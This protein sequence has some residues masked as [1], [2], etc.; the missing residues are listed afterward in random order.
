MTPEA[1]FEAGQLAV[2]ESP[3]QINNGRIVRILLPARPGDKFGETPRLRSSAPQDRV[4]WFVVPID[5]KPLMVKLMNGRN[6]L[7][8]GKILGEQYMKPY[9]GDTP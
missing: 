2:I 1:R 6:E 8:Q 7:R 3:S 9:E 5:G 4:Y